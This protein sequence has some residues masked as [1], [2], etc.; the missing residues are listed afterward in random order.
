MFV[1]ATVSRAL[2][3]EIFLLFLLLSSSSSSSSS[4]N[5]TQWPTQQLTLAAVRHPPNALA[6]ARPMATTYRRNGRSTC[7]MTCHICGT[8]GH[9]GQRCPQAHRRFYAKNG[10]VTKPSDKRAGSAK[11]AQNVSNGLQRTFADAAAGVPP[12]QLDQRM[13]LVGQIMPQLLDFALQ[14][15]GPGMNGPSAYPGANSNFG[16]PQQGAQ[17]NPGLAQQPAP[18]TPQSNA[19]GGA[20]VNPRGGAPAS[21]RGG[22]PVNTRGG[23][24]VNPGRGGQYFRGF[25]RRAPGYGGRGGH[26]SRGRGAPFPRGR[27]AP[28]YRG[29]GGFDNRGGSH[30]NNNNNQPPAWSTA[31]AAHIGGDTGMTGMQP[32]MRT[33]RQRLDDDMDEENVTDTMV[34]VESDSD[35]EE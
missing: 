15:V 2:A 31:S 26:F 17:A 35:G 30:N 29:R 27:G 21:A 9:V 1:P 4:T 5:N 10:R 8:D 7:T 3:R 22:A 20:N 32:D 18:T 23:A 12:A 19:R 24:P 34:K 25:G 6:M 16:R 11:L 13:Q 33:E 14:L 28:A